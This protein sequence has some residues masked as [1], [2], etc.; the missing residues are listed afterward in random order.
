ME[1]T[2]P[3]K[4]AKSYEEFMDYATDNFSDKLLMLVL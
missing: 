2:V 4:K 3:M 1:D